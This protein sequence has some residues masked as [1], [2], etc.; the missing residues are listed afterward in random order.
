MLEIL[1]ESI[2]HALIHQRAGME[3]V[4]YNLLYHERK[5]VRLELSSRAFAFNARIPGRYTA[6]GD[7]ISP[8]LKWDHT[9]AEAD[10]LALIVEDADAPTPHP[11]VHAI[12]V[13]LKA[14]DGELEEG[15]LNSDHHR[16]MGL[17]TGRNSFFKHAWLPPDP[18][19]GHGEHRYVFQIFALR[20][21]PLLSQFC[22]RGEFIDAVLER[23][24]GVG[25]VIGTYERDPKDI[26]EVEDAEELLETNAVAAV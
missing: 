23:A 7:G 12:V 16:G 14:E 1:P 21:G 15:A 11:L 2:G 4:V 5:T 10:S 20:K 22:G 24:V 13:D 6:D 9:P 18:P 8:P 26:E 3:N 19:P 17:E 25:C